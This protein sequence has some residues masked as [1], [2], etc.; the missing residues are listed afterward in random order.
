MDFLAT[1]GLL[2][3]TKPL[4]FKGAIAGFGG[5]DQIDLI[6]TAETSFNYASGVLTVKD[7]SKVVA[8]LN[9]A[10]NNYSNST[11]MFT[12]DGHQGTLITFT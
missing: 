5:N 3:L 10:G 7:G 2:D 12:S 6:K 4:D 1:T 8:S 11:F 9:F